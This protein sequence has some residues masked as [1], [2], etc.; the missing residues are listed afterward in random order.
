M[1]SWRKYHSMTQAQREQCEAIRKKYDA[2][3]ECLEALPS[4]RYR[5]MALTDLEDSM[6]NV[7]DCILLFEPETN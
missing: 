7:E 5:S 1:K 3:A 6:G 4:C 2:L